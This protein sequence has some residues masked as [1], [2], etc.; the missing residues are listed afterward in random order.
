MPVGHSVFSL[1][2]FDK[3]NPRR[4]PH[5]TPVSSIILSVFY[6]PSISKI[7]MFMT[8]LIPLGVWS[9]SISRHLEFN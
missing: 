3:I 6:P 2:I 7:A 1:N 5:S 4:D 9:I 8:A